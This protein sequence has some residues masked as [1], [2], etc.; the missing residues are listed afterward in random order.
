VAQ[1]QRHRSLIDLD[2][3]GIALN[4]ILKSADGLRSF[5]RSS[6]RS[7]NI[8]KKFADKWSERSFNLVA[9]DTYSHGC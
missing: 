9:V 6:S 2:T 5:E 8:S 7:A 4:F 1:V 3:N